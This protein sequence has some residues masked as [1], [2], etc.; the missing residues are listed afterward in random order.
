[1][2]VNGLVRKLSPL[3]RLA[4][5][6]GVEAAV[7][8]HIH[9]GDDLDAR[10]A[11]GATPLILA[12]ARKKKGVV[13]LLL[14]AGAAPTLVDFGGRDALAHA[15]AAGCPEIIALLMDTR[16]QLVV[17]ASLE[18]VSLLPSEDVCIPQL[19][20]V[21]H[22]G[23][24]HLASKQWAQNEQLIVESASDGREQASLILDDVPLQ[25]GFEGEW[26]EET[27]SVAPEGNHQVGEVSKNLH[28]SIGRH[29]A[30][31]TDEDWSEID[32]FLP[33][34]VLS[35][36]RNYCDGVLRT[37]LLRALREGRVS[38]RE[39]AEISANDDGSSN[40]EAERLLI[41]VIGE[42][43]AEVDAFGIYDEALCDASPDEELLLSE[44]LDFMQN[45]SSGRNEPFRFY[46]KEI[47]GELLD[48]EEEIKL[49]REIEEAG[50]DALVAL[51]NWPE[52]LFALIDAAGSIKNKNKMHSLIS[53]PAEEEETSSKGNILDEDE[54]DENELNTD[55]TDFEAA[56]AA[57][58][59][60]DKEAVPDI[61][62]FGNIRLPWEFLVSLSKRA[63]NNSSGLD[64]AKAVRRQAIARDR[65]TRSNLRLALS[66]AKKYMRS[67]MPLDDLIQEANIGLMK[68]VERYDWR[69]GF[70]FSTYA[71]WW[72]RQAI[73]RAIADKGKVVRAPVHAQEAARRI[74]RER[75]EFMA[76]NG[77][78]ETD[79]EISRRT[80]MSLAKTQLYLTLFDD[81]IS[82]DELDVV[83]GFSGVDLLAAVDSQNPEEQAMDNS[84]RTTLMGFLSDLNQRSQEIIVMRFGLSGEEAM[85]LEEVGQKFGLTRE[86]IR[87]IEAKA[88][89]KLSHESRRLVLMPFV[90]MDKPSYE[91]KASS[92]DTFA[93]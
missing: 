93:G 29:K 83:S 72:I 35:F 76:I 65:M 90:G 13:K 21:P 50:K 56:V 28:I 54:V 60:C 55:A 34:R 53:L 16:A 36:D 84:L 49:G 85:T 69:K 42:L 8:L 39:L 12:A 22:S 64:F 66:I 52:G 4:V 14:E 81:V 71:S 63:E 59:A 24:K 44:A 86:R 47:R 74:I 67:E 11:A 27:E 31:D 40:I 78:F 9:R 87:Q 17:D 75:N 5:I 32:L 79:S 62:T 46:S 91:A 19:A 38:A 68:A 43:G 3:F 92:G 20:S 61:E 89:K 41:F 1:M 70:R 45:L 37:F 77:R 23:A 25:A 82:L 33:D 73:T 30:I 15:R 48:A 26:E 51:R 10:D 88:L 2:R 58:K 18:G 7:R 80:G 57:V 6:S